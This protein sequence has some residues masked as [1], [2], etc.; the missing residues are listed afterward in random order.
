MDLLKK[1]FIT[2]NLLNSIC[3]SYAILLSHDYWRYCTVFMI[4]SIH[5]YAFLLIFFF[6]KSSRYNIKNNINWISTII[7]AHILAEQNKKNMVTVLVNNNIEY[8]TQYKNHVLCNAPISYELL[9][10]LINGSHDYITFFINTNGYIKSIAFIELNDIQ[11]NKNCL[12][13]TMNP[14]SH[15][16]S[17]KNNNEEYSNISASQIINVLQNII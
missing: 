11:S 3:L 17:L 9:T 12:I 6:S 4:I 5:I 1:I 14:Y 2:V 13:V 10:I 7:K 8:S 15:L 16:F